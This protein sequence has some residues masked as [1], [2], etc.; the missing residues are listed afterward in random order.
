M[1]T[2]RPMNRIDT[3]RGI[4]R[5]TAEAGFKMKRGCYVLR[6][7]GITAYLEA[8]GTLE[9]ATG[10]S[11]ACAF[12]GSSRIRGG[13]VR[14]LSAAPAGRE[15]L[16]LPSAPRDPL[17]SVKVRVAAC[18]RIFRMQAPTGPGGVGRGSLRGTGDFPGIAITL[19]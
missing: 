15:R 16:G 17:M 4:R 8:G 1:L 7:T 11:V 14:A 19:V 5:R 10:R 18:T 6:A 3:C 9:N 2:E 13:I 12:A